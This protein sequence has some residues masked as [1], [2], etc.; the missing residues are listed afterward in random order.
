MAAG[1]RNFDIVGDLAFA[2][3][4]TAPNDDACQAVTSNVA[5]KIAIVNF[6]GITGCGSLNVV[7]NVKAAGAIGIVLV[8]PALDDPRAF[9]GSAAANIPSV[10]MGRTDGAALEAALAAGPVTIELT[11]A[12]Q[13]PERDGDLDNGVIAH[14]WGHYLHHRLENCGG[15]GS[16]QCAGMSEGWGD[17]NALM[18]MAHEGDNRDGVYAEGY[19]ALADGVTPDFAYF[20]IRRYPYSRD[21]TKN[22]LSFR[23]ISNGVALPTN[24]PG[25]PGDGSNNSEVHNTG[26]IW[27][28]MMWEVFNVVADAHGVEVARRRMADYVVAGLLMSPRN[29]SFTEQ[30]DAILIAAS[31]MDSDDMLVM[32][33]AFAG[34]GIGSCAISP[35]KASAANAGVVESGT[36][37]AKLSAGGLTV[38]DNGPRGDHDGILDPGES[39]T[40]SLTLANNGIIAAENVTVTATS[41]AAGVTLGKPLVI[42]AQPRF[43]SSTVSIPISLAANAPVNTMVTINVHVAGQFTCDRNGVDASVTV[44]TGANPVMINASRRVSEPVDASAEQSRVVST[45]AA[46]TTSLRAFDAAC[47]A[48]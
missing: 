24:T 13:G 28:A 33:G 4:G 14:E 8:D 23:H 40:L 27:A 15:T 31:A 25:F 36:L 18:M 26:E 29:P 10:A 44:L 20:G 47:V 16:Q 43:S 19:Y 2:T 17:F 22:D 32:A 37:A 38:T 30:R 41:A 34:R 46:P 5:G 45:I 21:R 6:S 12:V 1:P 35:D 48:Q 42:A 9:A 11:S 39:G 3:D 7:N